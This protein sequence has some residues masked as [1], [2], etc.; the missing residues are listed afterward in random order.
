MGW[1]GSKACELKA[2][3]GRSQWK[4]RLVG[5]RTAAACVLGTLA[6]GTQSPGHTRPAL[7]HGQPPGDT[8]ESCSGEAG[9]GSASQ[10]HPYGIILSRLQDGAGRGGDS[11]SRGS[12]AGDA[13]TLSVGNF[14]RIL[15]W[16]KLERYLKNQYGERKRN[17]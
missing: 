15:N 13:G 8:E 3:V 16:F 12:W 1:A 2:D 10:G 11:P 5:K 14:S 9:E 17:F 7:P 4:R 6:R